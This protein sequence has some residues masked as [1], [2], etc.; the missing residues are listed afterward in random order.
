[1]VLLLRVELRALS[2]LRHETCG[3]CCLLGCCAALVPFV[4]EAQQRE[5]VLQHR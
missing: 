2:H 5:A 4:C 3:D 1:M